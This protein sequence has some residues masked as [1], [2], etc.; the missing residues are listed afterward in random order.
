M[1]DIISEMVGQVLHFL[2]AVML[3]AQLRC[4]SFPV[5]YHTEWNI[6][7]PLTTTVFETQAFH[8]QYAFFHEFLLDEN[9]L[10]LRS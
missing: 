10:A 9:P 6:Q 3:C 4:A 7:C 1:L 2:G 8:T 5:P